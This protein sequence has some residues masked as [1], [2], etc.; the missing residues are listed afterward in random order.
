[1]R[2]SKEGLTTST[3]RAQTAERLLDQRISI[4]RSQPSRTVPPVPL[5]PSKFA[6]RNLPLTM[7]RPLVSRFRSSYDSAARMIRT[8]ELPH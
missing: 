2:L 7:G 8:S 1:M 4:K 5:P 3:G 6:G